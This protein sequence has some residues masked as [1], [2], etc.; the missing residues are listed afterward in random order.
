MDNGNG[1]HEVFCLPA[2]RGQ[3]CAAQRSV[4]AEYYNVVIFTINIGVNSRWR[5]REGSTLE[6]KE[7]SSR[8]TWKSIYIALLSAA[9]GYGIKMLDLRLSQSGT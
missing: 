2:L 3:Y 5:G 1:S 8:D 4:F 7:Y 6:R 9:P